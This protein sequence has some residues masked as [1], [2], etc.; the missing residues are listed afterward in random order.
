MLKQLLHLLAQ[1]NGVQRIDTLAAELGTSPSMVEQML[2]TLV[3]RGYLKRNALSCGKTQCTSC[4]LVRFCASGSDR[5]TQIYTFPPQ[6][7]MLIP[8]PKVQ[9]EDRL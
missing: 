2:N 7:D 1:R 9:G 8:S 5:Q 6:K 4:A 3:S